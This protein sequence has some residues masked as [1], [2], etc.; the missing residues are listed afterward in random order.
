M[1]NCPL[2]SF[3]LDSDDHVYN[4]HCGLSNSEYEQQVAAIRDLPA[5]VDD[6]ATRR[7][8]NAGLDAV[9]DQIAL[10][11]FNRHLRH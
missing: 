9:L 8:V 11:R 7:L 6:E 1:P 3:P 10:A 4:V 2:C 5:L